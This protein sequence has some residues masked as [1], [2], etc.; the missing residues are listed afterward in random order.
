M[1][2]EVHASVIICTHNPDRTILSRALAALKIQ[3]VAY[4]N[5]E[6]L[7]VDNASDHSVGEW[8]DISWHPKGRVVRE[9]EL[10]LTPARIR[11][12]IESRAQVLLFVDD[13]NLLCSDYLAQG[14]KISEDN[15]HIGVWGGQVEP[16]FLGQPPNWTKL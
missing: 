11:G 1:G 14:L 7:I 5:W 12:M 15:P 9:E 13:D 2:D 8:A 16:E 10:G 4:N 6:L 3:D